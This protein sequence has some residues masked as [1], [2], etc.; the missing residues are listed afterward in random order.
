MTSSAGFPAGF[1]H[2]GVSGA[3]APGFPVAAGP[4]AFRSFCPSVSRLARAAVPLDPLTLIPNPLGS[5]RPEF[6]SVS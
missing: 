6:G 5:K 2:A 1:R 3:W 4:E